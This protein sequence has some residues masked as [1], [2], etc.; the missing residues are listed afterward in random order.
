MVLRTSVEEAV[1]RCQARGGD[2]LT[3]PAV[4]ADLHGQF[5]DLGTF[6]RHVVPVDGLDRDSTLAAV[7]AALK[8]GSYRLA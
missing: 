3:D 4:V 6:E 2:S 8:T 5:A 1:A 7:I